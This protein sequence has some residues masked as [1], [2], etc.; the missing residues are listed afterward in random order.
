MAEGT[1]RRAAEPE[2]NGGYQTLT[3]A[4]PRGE[5][6]C[7][8]YTVPGATAGVLWL[9]GVGGGWDSPA[10]GLYPAL[11]E[12]LAG[13]ELCGLR[14]RFRHPGDLEECA[15]DAAAGLSFLGGLGCERLGVVGHSFGGAVAVRVA[16]RQPSVTAVATLATQGY[17]ADGVAE[18]GPRA[19]LLL[20]HG[21]DDEVLPADCSAALHEAAAEPKRLLVLNGARHCLDE[22]ADRVR[23]ELRDFLLQRLKN[24]G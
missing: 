21:R 15:F 16:A 2:L 8:H 19:A 5:V 10:K 7:R 1:G 11:A 4:T 9:G 20:I 14:V 13:E 12:E 6:K 24:P 18:L 22:Q 23:R 3:L 17:G